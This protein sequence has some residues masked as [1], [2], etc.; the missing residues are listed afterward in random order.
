MKPRIRNIGN[1]KT[2]KTRYGKSLWRSFLQILNQIFEFQLIVI[3]TI[4]Q[5]LQIRY[6][7]IK[8]LTSWCNAS[9]SL[10][11]TYCGN[12]W[13]ICFNSLVDSSACEYLFNMQVHENYRTE[14]ST[15]SND[16]IWVIGQ[17]Q[18]SNLEWSNCAVLFSL[19][20]LI[21]FS[22]NHSLTWLVCDF[23]K[24]RYLTFS[25]WKPKRYV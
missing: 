14:I 11:S 15:L 9:L 4:K 17:F 3:S 23:K 8:N 16:S 18:L 19:T 24:N 20:K 10:C 25:M 6:L 7:I 5:T 2:R 13:A 21:T 1:F 12:A 22:C